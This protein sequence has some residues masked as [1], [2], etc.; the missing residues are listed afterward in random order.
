MNFLICKLG[1]K[2]RHLF[3]GM[4]I[5]SVLPS[6]TVINETWGFNKSFDILEDILL[7]E[8]LEIIREYSQV[9]FDLSLFQVLITLKSL[10]RDEIPTFIE[11]NPN[12]KMN[13][14]KLD[15]LISL[16]GLESQLKFIY[17]LEIFSLSYLIGSDE[18]EIVEFRRHV[19]DEYFA[20]LMGY[21][22]DVSGEKLTP[23]LL[24]GFYNGA[25]E[26]FRKVWNTRTHKITS[27][28]FENGTLEIL[29]K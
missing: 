28:T 26:H 29:L 21:P 16:Q 1:T 4:A 15:T 10:K 2:F 14:W 8:L 27:A 13:V 23:S 22:Y 11:K 18:I 17:Q 5:S 24:I 6:V 7:P 20:E 25:V 12:F 3:G 9:Y 19:E